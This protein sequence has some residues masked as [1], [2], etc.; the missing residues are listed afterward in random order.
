MFAFNLNTILYF[1]PPDTYIMG[2]LFLF[3][4]SRVS[5]LF[6]RGPDNKH[7]RVCGPEWFLWQLLSS[8]AIAEAATN[9]I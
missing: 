2:V 8:V 5:K 7:F 1:F 9:K 6:V 4:Y 3:F